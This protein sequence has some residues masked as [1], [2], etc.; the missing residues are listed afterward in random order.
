[1]MK[2]SMALFLHTALVI[3]TINHAYALAAQESQNHLDRLYKFK[4]SKLNQLDMQIETYKNMCCS[5]ENEDST[6]DHSDLI[7]SNDPTLKL[8]LR[9]RDQY[10]NGFYSLINANNSF[11]NGVDSETL[12]ITH[13][14]L[15][16][17]RK[18][19]A[20]NGIEQLI[21]EF[22]AQNKKIVLLLNS[23][24]LKD[25][26]SSYLS[27]KNYDIILSSHEGEHLFAISTNE[28][29]VSGG[30]WEACLLH[31]IID[32]IKGYQK[33]TPLTLTIPMRAI[34]TI[35]GITLMD[36]YQKNSLDQFIK[37]IL[38]AKLQINEKRQQMG[39]DPIALDLNQFLLIF[40]K[41]EQTLYR[42]GKGEQQIIFKL[43]D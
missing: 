41:G 34:Y 17:D 29:T 2:K 12:F 30:N 9:E 25:S 42:V 1:M 11:A 6:D 24:Y 38:I 26:S 39:Y 31:S 15:S 3:L 35:D 32:I 43:K 18:R 36:H 23:P 28:I 5:S 22:S 21:Q 16:Y 8:Y 10:R 20:Q 33:K 37:K 7:L 40:K 19:S 27:N 14:Q 13:P 4:S